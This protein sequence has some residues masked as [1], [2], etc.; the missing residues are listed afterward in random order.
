MQVSDKG[1]DIQSRAD[2]FN[3]AGNYAE[4]EKLYDLLLTQNHDNP[5]LLAT[6]GT[7]YLHDERKRYGT[8]ISFLERAAEKVKTSDVFCNLGIAY[9]FAGMHDKCEHWFK[10]SIDKNPSAAA[11]GNYGALF[12]GTG[13]PD[14]AI[15]LANQ[16][17]KLDQNCSVAHWNLGMALLEKGEWATGWD[18]H[19]W[20]LIS[21]MRIDRNIRELPIWDGTPEKTIAVYGEQGLGDEIMFASML[22]DLMET[23]TVIFECHRRLQKLFEHSFPGVVC[24]GT[25]EDREI[26][27]PYEY[28]I[29]YRM[30]VGSL[31]QRFRRSRDAFP[32]TPY[33]KAEPLPKGKKFRV[34]ISWT[35]GLKA[36]RVAV[37]TIPLAWWGSILDNAD[38]EFVSLQYTDCEAE[39]E[40]MNRQGYDIK[41]MPQAK[42]DDYYETAQLV[43]SCDLVISACTSVI[44]LAGALGVPCWVMVPNKPAWRY[45][46]S[47]GMPWYRSVRLY[48]QPKGDAD[49]WMPVVHRVGLDLSELVSGEKERMVA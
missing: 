25:R 17:I 43:A 2:E 21:K 19:E 28:E 41:Q 23:N 34:G 26:T 22:P 30:S 37:R 44:H 35:G 11:L 46:I 13:R 16:A 48:R 29:D 8:A 40:A 4:A 27:W 10:K 3:L 9:K 32:G 12:V 38:C 31:G 20:G 18:E 15:K 33:L 47:G 24:I 14:E 5:Y 7:L 49:A 39:I 1:A 6:M 36:G 42:A 45:G